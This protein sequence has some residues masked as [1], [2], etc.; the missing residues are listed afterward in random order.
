MDP[1]TSKTNA[2]TAST[3]ALL[4]WVLPGAGH[5]YAGHKARGI[6]I[7]AVIAV[8]FWG[9]VAIGGVKTTIQPKERRAWFMAQMCTGAHAFAVLS[10]ANRIPNKER[11]EYSEYVAYAPVDDIAVVYTGVAGLLNLLVILDVLGRPA[12][13]PQ[14]ADAKR[15]GPRREKT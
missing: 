13:S 15:T 14:T 3:A 5:I 12:P 8:T 10:L 4:S 2:A 11:W 9:G 1:T 6:I 7:L